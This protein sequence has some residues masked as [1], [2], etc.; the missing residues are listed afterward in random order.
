MEFIFAIKIH[1]YS[2]I[3]MFWNILLAVTPCWIAY[4]TAL[5]VKNRK[6]NKLKEDRAA[7]VLLFLLWL[8][9]LPNT[10]YLFLTVRHLVNYCSQFDAYRVCQMGSWIPMIFFV[11]A[12]IGLPTFYYALQKMKQVFEKVF[13]KEAA[14]TLPVV[15]IPLTAIG[16]MFGLYGRFN[17]WDILRHP[18]SLI[19]ELIGYF[20][21]PSRFADLAIFTVSLYAIYYVTKK[22]LK[23][24]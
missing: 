14:A 7:L 2:I 1:G 23:D 24:D 6:W 13:N 11:Y 12:L 5:G 9:F 17:T 15:V 8:F 10:A 21:D 16:V 19:Q 22:L 4:Y 18:I 3:F 20:V